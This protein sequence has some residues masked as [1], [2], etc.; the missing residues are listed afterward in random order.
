VLSIRKRNFTGANGD[1]FAKV[2]FPKEEMTMMVR[3][4][5]IA[6]SMRKPIARTEARKVLDHIEQWDESVSEQWKTRASVH[7]AK[8]DDGD[9]FS[10]AE[11]YKALA[12]REAEDKLS[13]ADRRHL[14]A[15]EQRLAEELAMAFG[16]SENRALRR[17]SRRVGA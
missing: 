14:G 7:Q 5:D 12:L 15:S 6:E 13:A 3:E 17:M 16:Q 8:L 1:R 10:I 9:P 11:V 4:G 2:F